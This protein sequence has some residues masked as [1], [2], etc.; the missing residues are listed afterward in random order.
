MLIFHFSPT[1]MRNQSTLLLT[2]SIIKAVRERERE[3]QTQAV[4]NK[5]KQRDKCHK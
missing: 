1:M 5:E 4:E 3:K 2:A